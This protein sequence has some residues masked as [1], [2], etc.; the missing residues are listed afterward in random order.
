MGLSFLGRSKVLWKLYC[1]HEIWIERIKRNKYER[2]KWARFFN[3]ISF[4]NESNT[5]TWLYRKK[6][7]KL[8][9]E[10]LL[11]IQ[12]KYE[13]RKDGIRTNGGR[14][15][16]VAA[17][18]NHCA[19]CVD[20]IHHYKLYNTVWALSSET[21]YQTV[22]H[23]VCDC[24]HSAENRECVKTHILERSSTVNLNK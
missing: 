15:A 11:P 21:A 4:W 3:G 1:L 14:F 8:F 2:K 13:W 22:V 23:F 16:R 10:Q 6:K 19:R 20:Y 18:A 17:I 7:T 24:V 9:A 5:K 12:F